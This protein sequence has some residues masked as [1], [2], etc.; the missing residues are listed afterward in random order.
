MDGYTHW[1]TLEEHHRKGGLGSALLE[2]LSDEK[3]KTVQLERMGVEDHFVH[4]LGN[5]DY[6][7]NSEGIDASAI[8][9][10]VMSYDTTR[11]GLRQYI[12]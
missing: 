3:I 11:T 10:K 5:Q 4:K 6:V 1:L 8:N 9:K 12:G 7:R 2:W